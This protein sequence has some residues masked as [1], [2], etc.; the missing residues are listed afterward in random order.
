MLRIRFTTSHPKDLT[1]DLMESFARIQKLCPHIHLP[2][3][4]APTGTGADRRYAREHYLDNVFKLR[5]TCPEIAITS[6]MIVGFP[7]DGRRFR[8]HPGSG[9]H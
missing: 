5:D 2:V 3:Q 7:G 8:G 1:R 9:P 4:S 6:D